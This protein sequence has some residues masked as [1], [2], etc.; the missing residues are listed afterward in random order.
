[1]AGAERGQLA[2]F[3]AVQRAGCRQH[4]TTVSLADTS[5][6]LHVVIPTGQGQGGVV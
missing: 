6:S 5:L 2:E 3:Q 4:M 1:M